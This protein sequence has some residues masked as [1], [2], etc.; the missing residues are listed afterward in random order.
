MKN[1]YFTGIDIGSDTTRVV[2]TNAGSAN[3]EHYPKVVATGVAKTRGVR[4]GYIVNKEEAFLSLAEAIKMAEK[5][6]GTKIKSANIT[7]NGT[8]IESVYAQGSAVTSRADGIISK[9]DIEKAIKE[10]EEQLDLKNKVILHAYPLVFKIDG[11]DLP[12][13]PEGV[14]GLKLEVKILFITVFK[15]HLEDMLS[16]LSASNIKVLNY[17]ANPLASHKVLLTDMQRNFGCVL[18]DIGAETV[19]ISVY[20]N[21]TPTITHVLNLG[22]LDITKDIALGL[23]ISPEEAENIKLGNINFQSV[24]KRKIEEIVE[25]RYS[26]IFELIDRYLKKI[27][28]SGLLPSGAVLIGGGSLAPAL[29]NP[30]KNIL[31]IPIRLG[32]VDIPSIKGPIKDPRFIP[33]YSVA[34]NNETNNL[35]SSKRKNYSADNY[36]NEGFISFIKNFFKQ[37][38]P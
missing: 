19:S 18:V 11:K 6:L 28:R 22:S 9:L 24:S 1:S 7:I 3:G 5:D 31:K 29:E 38:M 27:G 17:V 2:V 35:K 25:A 15:Q 36:E 21:G 16:V 8:G 23:T 4:Y 34:I 30:A 33:A 13:R 10:A 32:H 26:D 20:E 37:L 12:T 14:Y